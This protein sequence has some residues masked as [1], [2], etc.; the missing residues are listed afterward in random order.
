VDRFSCTWWHAALWADEASADGRWP[1]FDKDF[2]KEEK[3]QETQCVDQLNDEL[4][5]I[6]YQQSQLQS[7]LRRG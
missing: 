2:E 6:F 7:I 3:M 1:A 4:S 5:Q